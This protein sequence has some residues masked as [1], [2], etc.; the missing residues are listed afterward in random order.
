MSSHL[1]NNNRFT[2][3]VHYYHWIGI[4]CRHCHEQTHQIQWKTTTL[5]LIY[6]VI[7]CNMLIGLNE[8]VAQIFATYRHTTIQNENNN[9][10]PTETK[11]FEKGKRKS[12]R[13]KGD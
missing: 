11:Y 8:N 3:F 5:Q 13:K 4:Q 7:E 1:T 6:Y 10:I 2:F 12:R 9:E